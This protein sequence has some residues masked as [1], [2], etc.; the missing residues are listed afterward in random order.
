MK[1]SDIRAQFLSFFESKGHKMMPSSSLVPHNDPTLLFTNS[2]MVQFKDVFVGQ[3]ARPAPCATTSQRC[4]RAGGK[5]NDLENVGHTARHHTFFEMLGNFSFGDYFKENAIGYAWELIT[6]VYKLPKDRLW[7]TIYQEDDEAFEIWNKKMGV[8]AERIIR[9]GDNKGGRYAS[10]NFWQMADTGPCGPCT[11]IFYDHGEH[12]PGGLPGTPEEDG[13]RYIEIWNIV[14]MQFERDEEGVLHPLPKPCVDTGMGLERIAAV[15][16]N[17]HSNYEIDLFQNLI[18]AVARETGT[19]D[20]ESDSLKVIA[21]HIRA[22]SFMVADGILPSSE[23]R[24]Y[25]L[26]RIIRR[27]LRHGYQLGQD[28]PFF[29]RLVDDLVKEMGVAFPELAE[30]ADLVKRVLKQEEEKFQITLSKGMGILKDAL[31]DLKSGDCLDGQVAFTL[32]D[33]FGFP[34]DLT[35]DI[36]RGEGIEVD[37]AGFNKAMDIQKETARASGQFKQSA[38]VIKYEGVPTQFVGYE[39]YEADA[40]ITALYVDGESVHSVAQ[41]NEVIVILDTTPF[42]GESG[43]QVGDTGVMTSDGVRFAVKDTQKLNS[44]TFIHMGLI[45][46]GTLSVGDSIHCAIDV[47]RRKSISRNHSVTHMMHLAL[48]EVLGGHALQKGS[49]VDDTKARFDFAQETAMT[50]EQIRELERIINKDI[51]A[52]MPSQFRI[53]PYDEA[54]AMGAMALFGEKYGDIVRVVDVGRTCELDGGTHVQHTGEIGYFKVLYET[55]ISSGVRRIEGVTGW[56]ALRRIQEQTMLL[57]DVAAIQKSSVQDVAQKAE[58]VQQQ[59]KQSDKQIQQLT[60]RL[61]HLQSLEW[62]SQAQ[63]I[64]GVKCV[65]VRLTQGQAKDLRDQV[66]SVKDKLKSGVVV[67]SLEQDGKVSIAAGVTK[68][69]TDKVHAGQLVSKLCAGVG[70]KGGGRPDMAMGGGTDVSALDAVMGGLPQDIEKLL[71]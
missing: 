35:A 15:L 23:G 26:R 30:K 34:Y 29:H 55:G 65:F 24:G 42:Y 39:H 14:F 1:V 61:S 52:N 45:E 58:Q 44:E 3:E 51:M 12:I 47:E 6:E 21:D 20:L 13:D 67:L 68:D 63:D 70:G 31:K 33:T 60:Q 56:E 64:S 66:D 7:V 41:G 9:I 57:D 11:E 62:V 59:L 40:K 53:M 54:I 37:E 18:K 48:K 46:K 28:K 50:K 10:D 69:L 8:P 38:Q 25:V 22:C 36:C 27:A 5:H 17:V 4:V 32:Y 19:T 2:G 43:G 71:V 16:Q 49:L